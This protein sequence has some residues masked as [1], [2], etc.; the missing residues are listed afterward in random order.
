VFGGL[1]PRLHLHLLLLLLGVETVDEDAHL[2]RVA[3][4]IR[5]LLGLAAEDFVDLIVGE[6]LA[7]ELAD[8]LGQF[9]RI[10]TVSVQSSNLKR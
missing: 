8:P 7:A 10:A 6:A 9:V 1:V 5:V 4:L 2:A 3:P